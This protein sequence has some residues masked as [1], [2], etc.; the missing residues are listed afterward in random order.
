MYLILGPKSKIIKKIVGN[1]IQS[2]D[3]VV[4]HLITV[5][6]MFKPSE[7]YARIRV[8][9]KKSEIILF[10]DYRFIYFYFNINIGFNVINYNMNTKARFIIIV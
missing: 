3:L 2:G 1:K 5:C 8:V 7:T 10:L 6:Q 9:L 4:F